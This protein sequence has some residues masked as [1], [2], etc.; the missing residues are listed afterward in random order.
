MVKLGSVFSEHV[1][2]YKKR[3]SKSGS[4]NIRGWGARVTIFY[5]L[6]IG[7][8]FL[9][10]VR[11]FH[12]TVVM[13]SENRILSEENRVRTAII[14]A[15][16]GIF[17]DRRGTALVI[18]EPAFRVTGPCEPNAS[19]PTKLMSEAEW[20]A[21]EGEK[22]SVFLEK[23]SLR[24]YKF[25]Y[26]T[27]HLL[28]FLGEIT[29][30]EIDNP[31]Y[32]FQ[33]YLLGDKLGR[34]GLEAIFEKKMRGTDGRELIEVDSKNN[35]VRTLGKIDPKPGSDIHLSLD[36]ELQ[37]TAFDAMG[38]YAGAVVVSKPKTGEILALV[39]TPSFNANK[40][41]AG[42]SAKE[43]GN[44]VSSE[45]NPLFN[46]P[47]SGTYPPGS[48][49][50]ILSAVAGLESNAVTR[51]TLIE[52]VG[53][54]KVGNFSFANWYFTQYGGTEGPVN[55]V[56]AIARSNDIYF[57]KLGEMTGIETIA[58][59]ARKFGVGKK[60]GIELNGEAEG[61]MP[62]PEYKRKIHHDQWYLGDSYH[63]A[64]GQGD[65][66][67]TPLQ[68]NRWTNAIASNGILC[69]FTVLS[70]NPEFGSAR[71]HV[72][73]DLRLKLETVMTVTEGMIRACT[74]GSELS[75]QGTGYPLFDFTVYKEQ[76]SGDSGSAKIFQVP[77]ACKTGTAEFGDPE[78]RT[79]AWF[80]IFAPV[81][82]DLLEQ[83]GVAKKENTITGEPE[84]AVTVLVEKG[85][86]G[87]SV[88][89]PVAKKILEAWFKR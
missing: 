68:V 51:E 79:H 30:E 15:P 33:D 13:G 57:Y 9:L 88:A 4:T 54:L 55:L 67:T 22:Q 81:P 11:I 47:L 83:A 41:H 84:I 27:A 61:V 35:V 85:G 29:A 31:Y 44:L 73:D 69:P 5:A 77:T 17:Y 12:L 34:S 63:I 53:I 49:F 80:T 28:G 82:E 1:S 87:S 59:W 7:S 52:D 38:E 39:S 37:K 6:L 71:S 86:E 36:S 62:D 18:N 48:I 76:L 14:H 46:R 64:I 3:W 60:T 10:V 32:S 20:R 25:P 24:E 78:N 89:A 75:Y 19:C 2:Q 40:F 42:L 56:K 66:Q 26:E 58:E 65:L 23:D 45:D 21:S 16:R 74:G 72:C 70:Q 8:F 43:Y 50:K